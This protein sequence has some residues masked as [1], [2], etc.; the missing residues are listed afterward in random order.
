LGTFTAPATVKPANPWSSK[1]LNSTTMMRLD[2]GRIEQVRVTGGSEN[3]VAINGATIPARQ[4]QIDGA[5]RYKIW[6][7]QHD[8]PVMFI[9]EDDSGEVTFTLER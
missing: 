7:D 1:C 9:V 4:Y 5:T 6:I 8:I 3:T 2:N